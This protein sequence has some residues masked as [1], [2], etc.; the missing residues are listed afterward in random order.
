MG[1]SNEVDQNK[2]THNIKVVDQDLHVA[3][4]KNTSKRK[5]INSRFSCMNETLAIAMLF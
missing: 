3:N 1:I 2:N 4:S 5:Q